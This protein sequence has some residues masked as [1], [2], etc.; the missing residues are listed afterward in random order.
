MLAGC[1]LLSLGT[2]LFC[3]AYS[4]YLSFGVLLSDGF[5]EYLTTL[6]EAVSNYSVTPEKA[7]ENFKNNTLEKV[8]FLELLDTGKS[9]AEAFSELKN[10]TSIPREVSDALDEYFRG[11]GRRF[12]DCELASLERAIGTLERVIPPLKEKAEKDSKSV[13]AVAFAICLGFI[14][15]VI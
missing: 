2:L 10:R 15:L 5:L 4:R 14:I 3:R 11:L 1:I 8:G 12:R 7:R 9:H 6:K 13:Y